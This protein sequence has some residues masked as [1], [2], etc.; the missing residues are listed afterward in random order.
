[1]KKYKKNKNIV[2]RHI[3]PSY[4]FVDIT[5]CY[6]NSQEKMFVT[7]EIGATIWEVCQ[8]GDDF[9]IVLNNFLDK[10]S[11]DKTDEFV[12]MVGKDVKEYITRLVMEGFLE[13]K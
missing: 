7:D 9:E 2:I 13:E 6:N 11:D 4:F 1:M 8:D 12:D 3:E 10:L 5:K